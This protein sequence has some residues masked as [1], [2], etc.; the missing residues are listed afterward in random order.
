MR[1]AAAAASPWKVVAGTGRSGF[2]GDTFRSL[3]H[4]FA[5]ES[6]LNSP[7]GLAFDLPNQRL[8]IADM[9]N[10][11][12][13]CVDL[14]TGLL[15]T[16]AGIGASGF[17][18]DGADAASAKLHM[19]TGLA[20]DVGRQ[21]LYI[22]D[23]HNHRVRAMDVHVGHVYEA[24]DN[25]SVASAPAP[26]ILHGPEAWY[27]CPNVAVQQD[28]TALLMGTKF[29]GGS[30]GQG[31][32]RY[33]RSTRDRINFHITASV[34][35]G[36]YELRFRYADRHDAHERG[37][38]LMRLYVDGVVLDHA[39]PFRPTGSLSEGQR[40]VFGWSVARASLTAGTHVVALEVTGQGGPHI[41]QLY[42][43]PP[44]TVI[45]TVAGT[46]TPGPA[47]DVASAVSA[48][49]SPLN[50]PL[51]LVLDPV[52]QL[53]YIADSENGKVRRL[54]IATGTISTIAG[55]SAGA[56]TRDGLA[57]ATS[58]LF[59]PTGLALDSAYRYLYVTDALQGRVRRID[60]STFP[61]VGGTVT[62]VAGFGIQ[63][64]PFELKLYQPQGL[65]VDEAAGTLMIADQ[66]GARIRV[67]NFSEPLCPLLDASRLECGQE[68][69]TSATCVALGCCY[70]AAHVDCKSQ[71][72]PDGRV[73]DPHHPETVLTEIDG[74]ERKPPVSFV[75]GRSSRCCYPKFHDM[76]TLELLDAPRGFAWDH[77]ERALYVT[78]PK[79]HRVVK[80]FLSQ[81]RCLSGQ[82]EC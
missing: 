57:A 78:Q 41:D 49:T 27:T 56:T 29:C 65:V 16:I 45:S 74:K 11:A 67:V 38:R 46:G 24:E 31:Y 50:T 77:V 36:I 53:L 73:L 5:V 1:S 30:T 66:D 71:E 44:R 20:L 48:V 12:V 69:I 54:D 13:R 61:V 52:G 39:F 33:V 3:V 63:Q 43:K 75:V 32:A 18:G 72:S 55:G 70:D 23:T 9:G 51:G 17:S 80:L 68:G 25:V 6:K 60:L 2:G 62:T 37:A 28:V 21:R 64:A 40:T 59:R 76:K 7:W 26:A 81:G 42:V 79:L 15:E 8:Y 10:S 14:T 47:N 19:P 22:S 58:S 34:G 35:S 4:D 82:I